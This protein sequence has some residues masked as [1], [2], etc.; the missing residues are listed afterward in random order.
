MVPYQSPFVLSSVWDDSSDC[1]VALTR[2]G[3]LVAP[4]SLLS[5]Y[6]SRRT[7]TFQAR[8][9]GKENEGD[10]LGGAA[11]AAAPAAAPGPRPPLSHLGLPGA[12]NDTASSPK[13][14]AVGAGGA[15]AAK[16]PA[17]GRARLLV[18]HDMSRWPP[19]GIAR[20]ALSWLYMPLIFDALGIVWPE[21]WS[22]ARRDLPHQWGAWM[23]AYRENFAGRNITKQAV[24][25]QLDGPG[26]LP[27]AKQNDL[28]DALLVDAA[29]G[30]AGVTAHVN[31]Y[32]VQCRLAAPP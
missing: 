12:V 11:A 27:A 6:P 31:Q 2:R 28:V 14:A 3:S 30:R 18:G 7:F 1:V 24:L 8:L 4:V 13:R 9:A 17:A 32:A 15:R 5:S 22:F 19:G 16:R 29:N 25:A 23:F 26:H 10:E 20:S 21:S